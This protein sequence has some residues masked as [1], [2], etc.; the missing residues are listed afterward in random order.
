[1]FVDNPSD[2]NQFARAEAV[3]AFDVDQL[4]PE[5]RPLRLSL[6]MD[7]GRFMLVAREKE[8]PIRPGPQNG[9]RHVPRIVPS[10]A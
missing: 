6:N 4:Q 10:S 1:M 3:V 9:R 7:V 2:P 8:E 5:L